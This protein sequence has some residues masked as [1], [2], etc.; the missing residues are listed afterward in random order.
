[1][2]NP[3]SKELRDKLSALSEAMK[4]SPEITKAMESISGS[5]GRLEGLSLPEIPRYSLP[6]IEIP[7]IPTPEEQNY[8]QS[9][10]VLMEALAKE[11]LQ[12]K[13]S[14]P[15]NFN[16]AILAILYGGVQIHVNNLSQVS[17]HGIRVE[18]TLNGA[19]CSVLAHQT[20]VQ[21]LCYAEEINLEMP[22]N[23]IGFVWGN[24]RVEV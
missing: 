5:M 19:P 16:P 11:A 9:S 13:E 21:L 6:E 22:R 12:W 18:G 1:M 8:Y 17:F 3:I 10:A 7:D 2:D 15:P 20:T 14:L 23:P 4:P 24:E